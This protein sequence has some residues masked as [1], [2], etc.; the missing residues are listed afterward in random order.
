MT[1]KVCP[2]ASA[3]PQQTNSDCHEEA[4]ACYVEVH[5]PRLIQTG[6]TTLVDPENYYRYAGCGL[7]THYPWELVKKEK[8]PQ[9]PTKF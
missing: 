5:K 8:I 7:V 9:A 2:F 6:N 4:C 3:H 1:H